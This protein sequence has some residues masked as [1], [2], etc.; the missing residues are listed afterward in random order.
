MR[1]LAA[2]LLVPV[3]WGASAT[4][5]KV[6]DAAA[7]AVALIQASQ[8]GWYERQNCVSCHHQFQPALAFR[9][10]REHGIPVDET[11]AR[12]DAVRAFNYSDLDTL[13][14]Y[15]QVIE[16]AMTDAYQLVAAEAAG[17]R[18]NLG[19]AIMA[20]LLMSRQSADGHWDSFHQRPPS[21]Y[22]RFTQTTLGLM[23]IQSFGHSSQ[24]NEVREHVARA[25]GWLLKNVPR[26]TE[27]R[28][29]QLI[30]LSASGS[31][32]T[33]LKRFA[34]D[35]VKTQQ[36]HG[37]WGSMDG[38]ESEA[39]STG[40]A[41]V[42]LKRS[43]FSVLD[44]AYQRGIDFLLKTQMPDGSWHVKSRLHPPA[45]VSPP[46]FES[47]YPYGHDQFLSAQ[48]SNWAVIALAEAAGENRP[49]ALPRLTEAELLNTEPWIETILFGAVADV[50][51]GCL[52]RGSMPT[53]L[54]DREGTDRHL[55]DG[56]A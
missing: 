56:R 2:L 28:S 27:E 13:I 8:K 7:R 38:R 52:T 22:S 1:A 19:T 36:A 32:K 43:G 45:P 17:V 37:G 10:A 39:Y 46:Y 50:K 3:A 25:R 29:Y 55:Y 33:V 9:S 30:G 42:A 44:P 51:K 14:Q 21:S 12:A 53:R 18:P 6:R 31:D 16:P 47:G 20:R 23:A 40:E 15:N 24:Q 5:M 35:L 26:D 34:Q 41:L 54:R 49:A 4:E 48:G 11:I